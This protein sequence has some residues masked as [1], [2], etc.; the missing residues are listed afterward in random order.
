M[1]IPPPASFMDSAVSSK[2][3]TDNSSLNLYSLDSANT[4]LLNFFQVAGYHV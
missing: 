2:K 4:A 3:P 1:K